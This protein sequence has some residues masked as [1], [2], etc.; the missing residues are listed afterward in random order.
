MKKTISK[1]LLL[2]LVLTFIFANISVTSITASALVY[3]DSLGEGLTWSFNEE[4]NTLTF[5]G[6]GYVPTYIFEPAPWAGFENQINTLVI[7]GDIWST[8]FEDCTYVTEIRLTE[9]VN[10]GSMGWFSSL[11]EFQFLEN[12]FVDENNET[13]KSIGGVL[14][15]TSSFVGTT[16]IDTLYRFPINKEWDS[17][18]IP[19]TVKYISRS[20][21]EGC[22]NLTKI[23]IPSSVISI[24][25]DAF[26]NSGYYNNKSN[27]T[28]GVLYL[29]NCLIAVSTDYIGELNIK[30]ETRMISDNVFEEIPKITNITIPDSIPN[31]Q[32]FSI[33]HSEP[34]KNEEN[35][36]NGILYIDNCIISIKDDIQGDCVIREGTR[37]IVSGAFQNRSNITSL[38][39]SDNVNIPIEEHAFSGCTNLSSAFIGD[40]VTEI[41][42]FAFDGCVNLSKLTIGK[43]VGIIYGTAFS[44]CSSL[45]EVNY[46]GT[47]KEY[48]SI[49][50]YATRSVFDK[51]NCVDGLYDLNDDS[52]SSAETVLFCV[53][54]I[55]FAVVLLFV[56]GRLEK[57]KKGNDK[58]GEYLSAEERDK[59]S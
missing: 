23:K 10:L 24:G 55:I 27:W 41:G 8:I 13:C 37:K 39:I 43:N 26:E 46:L 11:S 18:E 28:N 57:N 7:D 53:I 2:L 49:T 19:D 22:K 38:I 59:N 32:L 25:N 51:V 9:K 31:D 47:K 3:S 4:T 42:D 56:I 54:T 16:E 45:T 14:Y 44:G 6:D 33:A 29:D 58:S 20:A 40:G 48:E 50:M 52:S 17:Y 21:F 12:I 35:W 34:A 36:E 30:P 1:V 5:S 15:T